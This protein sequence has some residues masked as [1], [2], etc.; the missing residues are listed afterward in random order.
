MTGRIKAIMQG[1]LLAVAVIVICVG[2][3]TSIEDIAH[4]ENVMNVL[5]FVDETDGE[6]I[7]FA[8]WEASCEGAYYLVLPS[9]YSQQKFDVEVSYDDRWYSVYIDEEKYRNGDIWTERLQEEIHQIKIVDVFGMTRMV[10]PFQV[11]VSEA[12]PAVLVTVEAKEEL[13]A[14]EE[15]ANKQYVEK[16]DIVILDEKGEVVLDETMERFKVRGNLTAEF[17]KKPFTFTLAKSASLCGMSESRNWHLLADATDGSHIRNKMMLDWADEISEMYQ[18]NGE[19]VDLFVN[20]EYQGL[21][22]LTETVEV[23]ESRLN[24]NPSNSVLVE[25]EL[26][27]RALE[28]ENCISTDREHYW[29]AH[30]D[31]VIQEQVLQE[32]ENYLNEIES[33]LYSAKGIDEFSGRRLSEL[34]DYDSWTDSWLLKEVSSDHDLGTTSQFGVVQDWG[35]RSILL[36]GPEWD[37]DGTLGNGMVPWSRNPKN[38]VTAIPNTKGI[39]SVNQNKWLAQMYQHEDF[40]LILIQKF[41][42]EVQPKIARLLEKEI[43]D[44]VDK[45]RRPALL[46][47]LRWNGNG[48]NRVFALPENYSLIEAEDYH[49]Y[50]VLDQH[51]EMI[52]NFLIEKEDFL[53]KL[54]IE[55]REFDVVIEEHNEEGMNLELNNDIYTWVERED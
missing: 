11:L 46:D 9:A 42:E 50:D 47:S 6:K 15:Y 55:E 5:Q 23:S 16:G 36:A 28:E 22:L 13:L 31:N 51:V 14:K 52:K 54:W 17:E 25:M 44:Y 32:I 34:L 7:S 20:G 37:F 41:K 33:V 29:V 30:S 12:V 48:V 26:D 3:K 39:K 27:Y 1:G 8:A 18:P 38:L 43:D 45:I 2:I 19:W 53:Q 40:K 49:K 35:N 21:Y 24:I 4:E 10:K